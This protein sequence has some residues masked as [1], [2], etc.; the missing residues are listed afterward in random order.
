MSRVLVV[1]D[2]QASARTLQLH[3]RTQGYDTA[4][5][6][7]A[8]AGLAMADEMRPELVILDIRMPGR[9]G[10]AVLPEIRALD[11]P[12]QVIM[13]TAFHDMETTIEAMQQ[14]AADYI[15][16][17]VDIDELDAA[18]ERILGADREGRRILASDAVGGQQ[19]MVGRS[20]AMKE[21]FKTIGLVARS[22]TT[23]L[24]TG[25]SGTG[26]EL[27]A[28]AVHNASEQA[29]GPFVV[30][31]CAAVVETLLESD[32]F[33]HE[34]GAF[35]G[36]VGRHPGKFALAAGGTIFL[37]EVGEMS[38]TMQA[39]LLRVLQYK[40]FT[41]LGSKVPIH[42]DARIV[43]A[44]NVALEECV[45][46]GR[47]RE[48]LYYRLQVVN[49]HL[50]PLRERPEDLEGLVQALLVRINA[51]L[52]SSIT[53]IDQKVL[54]C[55][56]EYAWPGNVRELE[57]ILLKA[58]AL[59]AGNTLTVDLLPPEMH[60][61]CNVCRPSPLVGNLGSLADMERYHVA[62]VLQ[63][64]G[65]HRGEACEILGVSRPRL[66][67]MIREYDLSPPEDTDTRPD[68]DE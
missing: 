49:I 17:P 45:A 1:D 53:H 63:A 52:R 3:L 8:E 33:G 18:L 13:I 44:T 41:P 60:A 46:E 22:N 61:S 31:N 51:E 15:H 29:D 65:W 68:D 21:V 4:V 36:A 25:E 62:K 11:P 55:F 64:T 37:D 9:S 24:I 19:R 30:V 47:F 54:D 27:V 38:A 5:A 67:R 2:D 58:V 42:S 7:D 32:M 16:K 40:E 26:K 50:P 57:N 23:V 34:K 28:H 43:A 14:G 6:H 12:P 59:S 35:T 20:R 48:D 39:K 66:R 56:A 10:L